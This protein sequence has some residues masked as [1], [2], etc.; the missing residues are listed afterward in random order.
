MFGREG[1]EHKATIRESGY[2]ASLVALSIPRIREGLPSWHYIAA[3]RV[4][5]AAVVPFSPSPSPT[6]ST[7]P[8]EIAHVVTSDRSDETLRNSVRTTYVVTAADIARNGYRTVADALANVP[9]VKIAN[10]GPIGT[11]VDYGIRGTS[12]AQVL[13]LVDG[14]PAPGGLAIR[15]N[16]ARFQPPASR[17]S[18]SSKAAARHSMAPARSAAS[19]TSSPTGAA[20]P[21]RRRCDTASFDDTELHAQGA[22][23][24]F[25][26]VV[27]A[28]NYAL[29]PDSIDG[30]PGPTT[31]NSPYQGTTARYGFEHALG[32][33]RRFLSR[34]A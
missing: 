14:Q 31:R 7:A 3:L 29:P 4:L 33:I 8:P 17:A 13:V 21:R 27:A 28:N 6:P 9:G 16:L 10:Y 32:A 1:T 23:L 18:K 19:S 11:Q 34:F 12:S 15:W 2:R 24:T 26:R 22:G 5:A 20:C 25:D 30:I